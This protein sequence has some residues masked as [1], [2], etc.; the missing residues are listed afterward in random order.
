[1][2]GKGSAYPNHITLKRLSRTFAG[3]LFDFIS[4]PKNI[5]E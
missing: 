1:M 3:S 2:G 4:L 5:D